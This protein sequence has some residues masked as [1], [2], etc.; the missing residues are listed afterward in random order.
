MR[1]MREREDSRKESQ[2]F[3]T[4]MELPSSNMRSMMSIA[5]FGKNKGFGF[6]Y[7]MLEVYAIHWRVGTWICVSGVRESEV[8]WQYKLESFQHRWSLQLGLENHQGSG[9]EMKGLRIE[10]GDTI[11]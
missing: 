1:G 2:F 7:V 3:W 9:K 8:H 11:K 5:G 10:A 6:R 4:K